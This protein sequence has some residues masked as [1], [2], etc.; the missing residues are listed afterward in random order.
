MKK[1]LVSIAFLLTLG[2]T[3]VSAQDASQ[4]KKQQFG[5]NKTYMDEIGVAADIQVKVEALKK[6]NDLESKAVREDASLAPEDKKKQLQAI[7]AKRQK[8][9]Y[10]LLTPE[11]IAK[12]KEIV[13]RIKD[14]NAT[15]GQ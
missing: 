3:T 9:I 15:L 1:V 5:W 14:S 13:T 7:G 8:G 12:S 2:L 6:E 4:P 11:Q 10:A